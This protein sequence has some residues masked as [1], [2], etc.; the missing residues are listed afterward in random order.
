MEVIPSLDIEGGRAVKRV[1]GVRGTG[2]VLG[3]PVR[4]AAGFLESG[5]AWVHVVDLDGAESGRPSNLGVLRALKDLGLRVQYGGGLRREEDLKAAASAGADRVIIGSAWVLDP[6]F[7]MLAARELG[8]DAVLAAVDERGGHVVYGGWRA[9]SGI[10]VEEAIRRLE[11]LRLAG[12]LYTQVDVEG[13][14]GG[15]DLSRARA[16]R[17][18]TGRLLIFAGGVSSISDLLGLCRAGMDAAVL[19]MALH[20][21]AIRLGEALRALRGCN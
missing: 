17:S 13:T 12:Y 3:D 2:I 15:P 7:L 11:P 14:M 4:I 18:L 5:A 9:D 10:S 20:S 16:V 21:G 19:G 8:G 6:S 1:R